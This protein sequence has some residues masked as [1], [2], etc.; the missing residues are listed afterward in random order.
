VVDHIS[1]CEYAYNVEY[2]YALVILKMF[3]VQIGH[4]TDMRLTDLASLSTICLIESLYVT[5]FSHTLR[6]KL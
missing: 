5:D 6:Y 4:T 2:E 3:V 1:L